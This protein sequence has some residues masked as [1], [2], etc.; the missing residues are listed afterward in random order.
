MAEGR[1]DQ[2]KLGQG[3]QLL[4]EGPRGRVEGG[5]TAARGRGAC[6]GKETWQRANWPRGGAKAKGGIGLSQR[7]LKGERFNGRTELRGRELDQGG[8]IQY[9]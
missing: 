6:K 3:T 7:G 8:R 2:S 9:F 5:G 1:E 4:A